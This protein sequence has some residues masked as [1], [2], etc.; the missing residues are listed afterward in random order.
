MI[1][2]I[3]N[4]NSGNRSINYKDKII[5]EL[6]T[7][8]N[9]I[10]H[11]TQR[12]NHGFEIA[13]NVIHSD[14]KM[15]IVIG[16]DGSINEVASALIHT[17]VPLGIIPMGSGNGL[18]RHLRIPLDF[19]KAL[20]KCLS[21]KSI[22]IDAV[23]FN[24]KPFFCTAGVGF[25][26]EVAHEFAKSNS[27]GFL[28]YLSSSLK[29]ILNYQPIEIEIENGNIKKIFSLTFANANQFGNNAYISPNSDLED[30]TFEI[31]QIQP[32][33][34]LEMIS[35]GFSLFL[36]NIGQNKKVKIAK[37]NKININLKIGTKM[38][39]DGENLFVTNEQNNI[40]IEHKALKIII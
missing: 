12:R 14:P 29:S 6:N 11:I 27:R 24:E 2:I 32:I 19:K 23:F 10:I 30:G 8:P 34:P 7:I 22:L 4:P 38:H 1:H 20:D 13:K 40:R 18:A 16:G 9:S 35:L 39:L 26:A 5:N 25:D 17:N 37:S 31:I 15:I 28:S 33:A 21:G 3:F 36:K